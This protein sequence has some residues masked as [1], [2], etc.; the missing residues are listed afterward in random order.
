MDLLQLKYFVRVAEQ[1]N[2]TDAARQFGVTQPTISRKV[3]SLEVE[4]RTTLFHRNGRGVQLTAAGRRF[5]DHI[6]G[7]LR[8]IDAAVGTLREGEPSYDGRVIGGLPSTVG[9]ILTPPLVAAFAERFPQAS[10][11]IVEGSSYSL[12][13]Q[14]LSGRLDFAVLRNAV[15]T[16]HLSIDPVATEAL[17][18]VGAR[19]LPQCGSSVALADL[20]DLPLLLPSAPH[21]IRSLV[22]AVAA[23]SGI[24]LNVTFEVDAVGSLLD[25]AAAGMGYTIVSDSALRTIA[26]NEQLWRWR[27]N[28]PGLSTILCLVTSARRPRAQLPMAAVGLVREVLGREFG[29]NPAEKTAEHL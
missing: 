18:L 22:D 7:V 21:A 9:K 15:A 23:R 5:F 28:A 1:G 4:L 12:Y 6:R 24:S 19:P 20:A 8:S 17:Y 14:L 26:V 25:L 29:L 13:G 2:F 11:S 3:R 10:L 27:I 16:P